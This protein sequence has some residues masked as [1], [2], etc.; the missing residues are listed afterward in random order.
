MKEL[1]HDMVRRCGLLVLLYGCLH[2]TAIAQQSH[3]IDPAN[4]TDTVAWK[5]EREFSP[6]STLNK[7]SKIFKTLH[8]KS[9]KI[10]FRKTAGLQ[11]IVHNGESQTYYGKSST[12]ARLM[13]S[14]EVMGWHLHWMEAECPYYPYKLFSTIGF[15]AY[16]IDAHSGACTDADAIRQWLTSPVHD[17]ARVHHTK[18]LLTLTSYGTERN[19]TFLNNPHAW[20]LLSDSVRSLIRIKKAHGIDLD[21]NGLQ[22]AMKPRF[23]EFI[24]FI[25]NK[26]GDSTIITLQIPYNAALEAYDLNSL[27]P[28][29]NT[30]TVQGYDYENPTCGSAPLPMAPLQSAGECPSLEKTV[31]ALLQTLL[32][33][34]IIL[35][36]PLYGTR[37]RRTVAGWTAM[38]N[39]PYENIRA[40]YNVNHEE[41]IETY[42][43]S[44][45]VRDGNAI[46]YEVVWYEGHESLNRKFSWI[47]E[48][49]LKGAG[50]WGLGYDGSHP[51]IWHAVE[52]HFT[53]SPWQ[54]IE[55]IGYDNGRAY[56]LVATLY[57]Y[58]KL[59]GV[60][61]FIIIGFFLLGLLLSLLDWRVRG[62][63]FN[64]G[65]YRGLFAGGL[66][67]VAVLAVYL[68]S[69]E[70][71]PSGDSG[72]SM[73]A[74]GIL[75]GA[76]LVY[77]TSTAYLRYKNKLP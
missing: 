38:D 77:V 5:K 13:D 8:G 51:E 71:S 50:L 40:Q 24:R 34:D 36:F 29:I 70:T 49:G 59:I 21:F 31:N 73:F 45:M 25:R 27:K 14:T 20:M 62:V 57:R 65:A 23:T 58:R 54:E 68:L 41:Y 16:D 75:S 67:S 42:S 9:R 55:P 66:I 69:D 64:S 7:Y 4:A 60:S 2:A 18:M 74:Y 6:G 44:S 15:F 76:V 19:N 1:L 35:G 48:K 63:F 61:I 56:S 22:P 30:F 39:M 72:V 46:P 28:L 33:K 43:G 53:A 3:T 32:P 52:S 10:Y 47:K 11:E 26:L 12:R 17:S 37:W